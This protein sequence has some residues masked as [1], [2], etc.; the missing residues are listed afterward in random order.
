MEN[1]NLKNENPNDANN[2]LCEVKI[3]DYGTRTNKN[4]ALQ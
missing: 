3:A 2:V 1:D 4:F